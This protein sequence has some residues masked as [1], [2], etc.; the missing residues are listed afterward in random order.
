M[1]EGTEV[2]YEAIYNDMVSQGLWEEVELPEGKAWDR[3]T[4]L[5]VQKLQ[6]ETQYADVFNR[7]GPVGKAIAEY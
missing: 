4:Y 3:N 7:T 5:E 2:N 6:T 1:P